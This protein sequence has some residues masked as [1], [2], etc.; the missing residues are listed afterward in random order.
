K[1]WQKLVNM[2]LHEINNHRFASV[3]QNPIREQDAPGY[4]DIVKQPMDLKSLKKRL[5]EG[6]IHDTNSFHRDLMLMF[7]NASVFNRE[8]T[9]IHQMALEMKDHVETQILDFRRSEGSGGTHEPA[10][11]RKSMAIDGMKLRRL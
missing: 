6:T 10:T 9:D 1:T 11:R 7:M 3:F 5:R 4:Y 2:I 8:E